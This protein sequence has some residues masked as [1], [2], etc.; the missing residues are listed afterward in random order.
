[1]PKGR[2]DSSAQEYQQIGQSLIRS[3]KARWVTNSRLRI[4]D[5]SS[6]ENLP[7]S[8]HQGRI[9]AVPIGGRRRGLQIGDP[10]LVHL[11]DVLHDLGCLGAAGFELSEG[12]RP[13]APA[14]GIDH[15]IMR[16]FEH[17]E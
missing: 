1:M 3:A 4:A 7:R 14:I 8:L 15:R 13:V 6:S 12:G 2:A 16:A 9:D 5:A 11:I 17:S 10:P